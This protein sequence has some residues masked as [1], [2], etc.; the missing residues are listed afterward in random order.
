[1]FD[2]HQAEIGAYAQHS[3]E[4]MARVLKFVILTIR[5][6]LYRVPA[7]MELIH[8]PHAPEEELAGVL[9]GHKAAAIAWIEADHEGVYQ[10]LMAYHLTDDYTAA[11]AYLAAKPGLGYVKAGFVLQ[12]CFGVVGCLDTHNLARFGIPDS[13]FAASKAKAKKHVTRMG[14]A[15]R[16]VLTCQELGG[17]AYLWDSWCEFVASKYPDTYH[18]AEHVSALHVEAIM[19]A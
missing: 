10:D 18:D 11:L 19:G 12:L 16:Y 15:E 2:T 3:P 1:M 9:F 14:H 6:P 17:C 8:D 7:D 13:A 5:Q 4:N